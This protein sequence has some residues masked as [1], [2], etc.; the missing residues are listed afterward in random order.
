[1]IYE[2]LS[3]YSEGVMTIVSPVI[4][5]TK[6]QIDA[7]E[8]DQKQPPARPIALTMQAER[9]AVLQDVQSNHT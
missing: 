8:C 9:A 1:M 6:K 2:P 5:Q 4:L 7:W 3:V